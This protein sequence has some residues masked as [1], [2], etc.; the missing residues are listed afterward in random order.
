M[1]NSIYYY[2]K[3]FIIERGYILIC[4]KTHAKTKVNT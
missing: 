4:K 2:W 3:L 1:R